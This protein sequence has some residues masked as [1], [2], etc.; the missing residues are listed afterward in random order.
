MSEI[1]NWKTF[2]DLK[3]KLEFFFKKMISSFD[4]KD[5]FCTDESSF[6]TRE[7]GN[8]AYNAAKFCRFLAS[9]HMGKLLR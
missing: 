4:G 8:Q 5:C 2:D 7:S 3:V 6:I 1:I 9:V